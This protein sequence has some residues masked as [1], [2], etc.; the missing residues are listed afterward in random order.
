[1]IHENNRIEI[2]SEEMW[3]YI[4]KKFGEK[5]GVYILKCSTS[6]NNFVPIP[7]NRLLDC[8]T[9]GIL[10][11][12][13]ADS[14]I[15]RVPNLKKSISPH[16]NSNSH[17]CGSRYKSNHKFKEKFP[18]DK[19]YLE[20]HESDYPRNLEKDFLDNYEES[21]GELPPFNRVN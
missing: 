8:D 17:Q 4:N 5:G 14:F 12:G 1:M 2:S 9:N 3:H 10:Y 6:F 11:I 21:F 20:L 16:Y 18:F 7:I 15:D 19:L 13:K